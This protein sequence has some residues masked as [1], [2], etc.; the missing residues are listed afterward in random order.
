MYIVVLNVLYDDVYIYKSVLFCNMF[1]IST[2]I[3]HLP[4]L[5]FVIVYIQ[6]IRNVKTYGF[7]NVNHW[8]ICCILH[9]AIGKSRVNVPT[10]VFIHT[11][12]IDLNITFGRVFK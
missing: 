9:V 1:S 7:Y 5:N 8:I 12:Y 3:H 6:E 4:E 11:L 2:D 10:S